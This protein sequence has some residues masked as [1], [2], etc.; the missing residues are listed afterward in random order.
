MYELSTI[1][2]VKEI[3]RL[4]GWNG[5][6]ET[7]DRQFLHDLKVAMET[8]ND[9]PNKK[10]LEDIRTL[11]QDDKNC[12]F[13]VNIREPKSIQDFIKIAKKSFG[14][15]PKTIIIASKKR[16]NEISSI[17]SEINDIEYDIIIDNSGSLK[18]LEKTA[19]SFMILVGKGEI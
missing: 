15:E 2:F 3:A 5:G 1:D 14:K 6:K 13:F 12:C 10:V 17:S 9:V 8:W 16:S 4:C 18:K 7:K 11:N 19:K